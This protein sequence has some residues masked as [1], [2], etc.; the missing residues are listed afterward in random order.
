M[1]ARNTHVGETYLMTLLRW[2][3]AIKFVLNN[4]NRDESNEYELVSRNVLI[5]RYTAVKH[6]QAVNT[7]QRKFLN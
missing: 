4:I 3:L 2:L 6:Y 7:K 5:V 1:N